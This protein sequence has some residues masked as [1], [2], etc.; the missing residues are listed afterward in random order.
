MQDC[1]E[2]HL[3]LQTL[4]VP[5]KLAE[6]LGGGCKQE[7]E[8]EFRVEP[9]QRIEF[10]GQGNHRVEVVVGRSRSRRSVMWV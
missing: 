4:I 2:S 8:N 7:I 1:G 10:M 9:S 5:G 3:G 6:G